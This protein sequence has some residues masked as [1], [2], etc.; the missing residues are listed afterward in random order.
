[1]STAIGPWVVTRSGLRRRR[2]AVLLPSDASILDRT[3]GAG[4]AGFATEGVIAVGRQ[5]EHPHMSK[6]IGQRQVYGPV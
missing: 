4:L 2:S 6:R 5:L 1:M 3:W